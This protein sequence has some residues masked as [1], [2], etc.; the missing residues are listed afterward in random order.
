MFQQPVFFELKR[1]FSFGGTEEKS[2]GVRPLVEK[3]PTLVIFKAR[4]PRFLIHK[5]ADK[6]T[7]LWM[8]RKARHHKLRILKCVITEKE[9]KLVI[10]GKARIGMIN[11]FRTFAGTV[12]QRITRATRA[13]PLDQSFWE[14]TVFTAILN[15]DLAVKVAEKLCRKYQLL[16]CTRIAQRNEKPHLDSS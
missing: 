11:F 8:K 4:Q 16:P 6:Q 1:P 13:K 2:S 12:A 10:Q 15:W 14:H 9:V 3:R 7:K 5:R